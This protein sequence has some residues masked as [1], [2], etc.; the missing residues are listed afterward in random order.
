ML[1][2]FNLLDAHDVQRLAGDYD[3]ARTTLNIPHPYEDGKAEEWISTH[4]SAFEAGKEVIFAIVHAQEQYLI[5]AIGI[6][7]IHKEFEKAEIGYWIGK[8]YW[9][10][11]YCTEAVK[12]VI[13]YCFEEMK[14]NRV[15]AHHFLNNPASGRVMEKAGMKK[16]GVLRQHDKKWDEFM[17]TV[18]YGALRSD[19]EGL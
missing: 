13:R 3:I 4:Q 5:G 14:L 11:G 15:Y 7:N 19:F 10:Q 12:A 18:V 8:P 6:S 1:R 16:E 2:P 17:D 9:N